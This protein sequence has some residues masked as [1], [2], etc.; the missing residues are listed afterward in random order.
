M[1]PR[2]FRYAAD[3]TSFKNSYYM[4]GSSETLDVSWTQHASKWAISSHSGT[5]C[6][7]LLAHTF[8]FF[9]T[10]CSCM[11]EMCEQ[12]GIE[13]QQQSWIMEGGGGAG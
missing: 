6:A 12:L 8:M 1:H 4:D 13:R 3:G 11:P 5:P 10:S 7:Y 2:V 9:G